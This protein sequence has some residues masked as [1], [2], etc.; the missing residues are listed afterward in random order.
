MCRPGV[1]LVALTVFLCLALS[2]L[3]P[4]FGE[5]IS[6]DDTTAAPT[7]A[8][9]NTPADTGA[10]AETSVGA[11]AS[12]HPKRPD[13]SAFPE[14]SVLLCKSDSPEISVEGLE[15]SP[16]ETAYPASITKLLTALVALER[17]NMEDLVTISA[18]TVDLSR[19][20]SKIGAKEGEV[21]TLEDLLY[22]M[23]LPSGCDAARAIA[24]HIGGS[25][26]GFAVLMN[27]KAAALH[28]TSSHFTNASGLHDDDQ[29][30]TARDLARLGATVAENETLCKILQTGAYEIKEQT[31]GRTISVRNINRL[32]TDPKPSEEYEKVTALYEWC[33]GGKTGS[34][35]AAGRTYMA[36][37]RKDGVTLVCVLLGDRVSTK[38][39]SD[40]AYD[41]VQANR[42]VEA[43]ALFQYGFDRIMPEASLQEL[44]SRGLS[45]RFTVNVFDGEQT[46]LLTCVPLDETNTL[47]PLPRQAYDAPEKLN[48]MVIQG[49]SLTAPIEKGQVVGEVAYYLED[50]NEPL[51]TLPL[52]AETTLLPVA[53]ASP[54]PE[55]HISTSAAPV[56]SAPA[57][58][59]AQG[60]A[61]S[62][63]QNA[64]PQ[65]TPSLWRW[66][67]LLLLVAGTGVYLLLHGVAR[68]GRKHKR[69]GK[70]K[71]KQG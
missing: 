23:L 55:I 58:A 34:T 38:G 47:Y 41:E 7:D 71:G 36:M 49:V 54:A 67:P 39:L 33:I 19:V 44:I 30:T 9:T 48:T 20:N 61:P 8:Q 52:V 1:L 69:K 11:D 10:D 62:A 15:K 53:T 26:E 2:P 40:R 13:L 5:E 56:S 50:G 14:S 66:L 45:T 37:A 70:G 12:A 32:V 57:N 63:S 42:F 65:S 25:E 43:V 35:S 31:T 16:D 59:P 6:P 24:E 51:F 18:H 29:Y 3:F 17:G 22:G 4:T 28:M 46:R 27:E 60:N 64:S 21:Y 68:G